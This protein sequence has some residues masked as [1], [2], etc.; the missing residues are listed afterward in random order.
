MSA[1]FT[2]SQR[3]ALIEYQITTALS[4]IISIYP[5]VPVGIIIPDIFVLEKDHFLSTFLPLLVEEG[6]RLEVDVS[7]CYSCAYPHRAPAVFDRFLCYHCRSLRESER[8]LFLS[9]V[10]EHGTEDIV[11]SKHWLDYSLIQEYMYLSLASIFR[12]A[13]HPYANKKVERQEILL[14]LA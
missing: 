11:C 1:L 7:I 3:N 8:T 6:K 9:I 14:T 13:I 4:T 10:T 12:V 5:R 2:K